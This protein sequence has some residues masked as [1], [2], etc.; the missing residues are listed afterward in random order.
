MGII[1]MQEVRIGTAFTMDGNGY[2]TL[3]SEFS[4]SGRNAAVMKLK[5]RNLLTGQISEGVYK[6]ADKVEEINLD[7]RP[8]QYSYNDGNDYVFMDMESY[9]QVEI[10]V[11][12]LGDAVY[13]LEDNMEI[14]IAFYE[15]RA[16][17]VKLPINIVREI[18]E[19]E[20]GIKGDTSGKSL[21]RAKIASGY[22]LMVPLFCEIGT[23]IKIDTRDGSY[24][25]RVK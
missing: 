24:V 25:E 7:L 14:E 10:P 12:Q 15:G 6:A 11:E 1:V 20:P 2:V 21:K 13:F 16:V 19:T 18:T 23:K 3:K 4:K 22:E 5:I 17:T 9:D 8:M